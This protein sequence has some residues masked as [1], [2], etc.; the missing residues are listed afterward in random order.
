MNEP[1][2]MSACTT[3]GL[4]CDFGDTICRC[5]LNSGNWN[6]FDQNGD[7]PAMPD[8]GGSCTGAQSACS[9][10][11]DGTCVCIQGD[12]TCDDGVVTCPTTRPND[13][14]SCTMFP[15]GFDCEYAAGDCSCGTGTGRDWSCEG[16]GGTCPGM[17]P[18]NGD[19]C[20]NPGLICEYATQ[21]PGADETCVCDQNNDWTC[22]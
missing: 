21:G 14:A 3:R 11:T 8:P 19:P 17:A 1:M 6:C 20:M 13:G 16:G 12:F 5:N 10:G 9:Y 2:S 15:A 7:C 4:S 22:I 18:D